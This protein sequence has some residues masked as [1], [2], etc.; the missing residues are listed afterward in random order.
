MAFIFI[1]HA[2]KESLAEKTVLA[3]YE[4]KFTDAKKYSAKPDRITRRALRAALK[5]GQNRRVSAQSYDFVERSFSS[6]E[7]R[8]YK[9]TST[10][11]VL[12]YLAHPIGFEPMTFASGG[13]RSIQLSYG[14]FL[15]KR[16][17]TV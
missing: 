10:R 17:G 11:L 1:K 15:C 4:H 13:Q 6:T 14:C 16:L 7:Y 5:R 12:L 9:K 8:R 2:R 3:E